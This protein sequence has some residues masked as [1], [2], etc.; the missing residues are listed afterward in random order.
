MNP[1]QF[2]KRTLNNKEF[3]LNDITDAKKADQTY[4]DINTMLK[5]T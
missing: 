2:R 3:S 5:H 4:K 1:T